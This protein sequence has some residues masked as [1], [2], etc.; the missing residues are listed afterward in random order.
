M[1]NIRV[2]PLGLGI[3]TRW[4]WG[5][6]ETA[7]LSPDKYRYASA[8]VVKGSERRFPPAISLGSFPSAPEDVSPVPSLSFGRSLPPLYCVLPPLKRSRSSRPSQLL[9]SGSRTLLSFGRFAKQRLKSIALGPPRLHRF[10]LRPPRGG[11]RSCSSQRLR[12]LWTVSV[13]S[14]APFF[15]SSALR[16]S[17]ITGLL[18]YYG[19]C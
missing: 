15:S 12:S 7:T 16:S 18:R 17:H 4:P 14:L 8:L 1:P 2:P 11:C 9:P 6:D 19:F 5:E 3:S 10:C 13:P